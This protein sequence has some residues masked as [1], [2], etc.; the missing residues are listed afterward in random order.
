MMRNQ[1]EPYSAVTFLLLGL[2]IGIVLALVRNPKMKQTAKLEGVNSWRTPGTQ[3]Q[4][5]EDERAA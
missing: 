4:E 5:E 3:P 1:Y 2:G